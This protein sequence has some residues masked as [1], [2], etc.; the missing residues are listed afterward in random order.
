MT[1][2]RLRGWLSK[3]PAGSKHAMLSAD[4]PAGLMELAT[5][6][7]AEVAELQGSTDGDIADAIVAAAQEYADGEDGRCKFVIQWRGSRAKPL[8][9][10][11]HWANPTPAAEADEAQTVAA[12]ISDA[13]IIR[14]LL[15]SHGEKD[16]VLMQALTA[17]AAA[18]ERVIAMQ[19][20]Q[21]A[22]FHQK[23]LEAPDVG[24][25]VALELT[26]IQEAEVAQRTEALK[27]LTDKLPDVIDLAITA[28]A[29]KL[30]SSG[31]PKDVTPSAPP[32][33]GVTVQAAANGGAH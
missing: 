26:D 28:V 5:W 6:E 16:R 9:T 10:V 21:L 31:E 32:S 4:A 3:I 1:P 13:T 20:D 19:N 33:N 2:D 11:T 25:G 18:Y 29:T 15:R 24:I 7:R 23:Q 22:L 12:G 14:D 8:K 30:M 27:A 17:S